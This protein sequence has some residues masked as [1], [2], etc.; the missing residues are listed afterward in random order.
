MDHKGFLDGFE[1][2]NTIVR[3]QPTTPLHGYQRFVADIYRDVA[4]A[5]SRQV[6][7]EVRALREVVI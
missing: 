3:T 1:D 5:Y 2:F 4:N 7:I 6:R